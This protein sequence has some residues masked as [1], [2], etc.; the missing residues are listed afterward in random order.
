MN[1]VLVRMLENRFEKVTDVVKIK[2][3]IYITEHQWHLRFNAQN[4]KKKKNNNNKNRQQDFW[5][6]GWLAVFKKKQTKQNNSRVYSAST[7]ELKSL[8]AAGEYQVHSLDLQ[9]TVYPTNHRHLSDNKN[10]K[11]IRVPVL[12]IK[13]EESLKPPRPFGDLTCN[14]LHQPR[15][16]RSPCC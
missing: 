14:L 16:I 5:R 6:N 12:I 2:I 15:L 9:M 10:D 1:L 8:T 7:C 13:V 3:Q 11:A 4:G